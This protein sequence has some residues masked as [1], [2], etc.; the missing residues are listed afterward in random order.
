[1]K[2]PVFEF[3]P[4]ESQEFRGVPHWR[5]TR[6]INYLVAQ[7]YKLAVLERQEDRYQELDPI[8]HI[9]AVRHIRLTV[10]S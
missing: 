2:L 9:V 5:L 10:K 1:M 4:V 6:L 8:F 7:R 3:H